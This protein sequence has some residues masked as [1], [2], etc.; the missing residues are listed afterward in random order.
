[1][2]FQA[3]KAERVVGLVANY[4]FDLTF[5]LGGRVRGELSDGLGDLTLIL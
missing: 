3:G 1:M 2:Q 4:Q 5:F